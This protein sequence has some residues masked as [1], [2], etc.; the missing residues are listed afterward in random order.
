MSIHMMS[1]KDDYTYIIDKFSGWD[2][3]KNGPLYMKESHKGLVISKGEM[4]G[5]DDSDFY[6]I[7]WNPEK[8]E[9]ERIVYAST[10]GWTYPNGAIVD[11]SP[12][13]LE[14]YSKWSAECVR[15]E[16]E[17]VRELEAKNPIKGKKV[18]VISGY[19]YLNKEGVIFWR[20]TNKFKTYFK[21]GYNHPND[22]V[23]Q[24]LG[25]MT[26]EGEKFFIPL[27]QVEVIRDEDTDLRLIRVG[28]EI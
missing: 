22:P 26:A 13:V 10:R 18:R 24:V 17:K 27:T 16:Q 21:N 25:I 23:N 2:N 20:G 5:Y 4:N 9:T 15:I 14:E 11:A 28:D 6:A 3:E 12:E 7:V 19:K 1:N 8:K